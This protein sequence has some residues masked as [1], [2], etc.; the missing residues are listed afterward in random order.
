MLGTARA[1]GPIDAAPGEGSIYCVI[2]EPDALD[3]R[4]TAAGATVVRCLAEES[5]GSRG[6]TIRGPEGVYW[7]FGTYAGEAA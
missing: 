1:E 3:A 2:D 4:A 7:S 6:F 5:Y